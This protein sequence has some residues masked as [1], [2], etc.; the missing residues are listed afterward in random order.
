MP[1]FS[2]V[3][4]VQSFLTYLHHVGCETIGNRDSRNTN[5]TAGS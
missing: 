2:F 1:D 3:F 4:S 5:I